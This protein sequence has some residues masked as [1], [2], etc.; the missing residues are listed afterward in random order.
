MVLTDEEKKKKVNYSF[1]INNY[2]D[3]D[4]KNIEK[5]CDDNPKLVR[6]IV[7]GHEIGEESLF[8]SVSVSLCLS[9][10]FARNLLWL[11]RIQN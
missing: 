4:L 7:G 2:T 6:Y 9:L 10:S 8:L 11:G 3:Q 5:F 1:T